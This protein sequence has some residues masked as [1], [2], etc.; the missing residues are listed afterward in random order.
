MKNL[1]IFILNIFEEFHVQHIEFK[2]QFLLRF[3]QGIHHF[4]GVVLEV[5]PD[6]GVIF[7]RNGEGPRKY[8]HVIMLDLQFQR[9]L[10]EQVF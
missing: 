4:G 1:T 5:F 7:T 10:I 9:E 8:K 2:V 3:L 6:D